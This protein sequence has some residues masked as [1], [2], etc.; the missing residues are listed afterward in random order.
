MMGIA[1][2]LP[3]W[4]LPN[5]PTQPG[6]MPP[7]G[8]APVA[9]A[10]GFGDML[11]KALTQN[12]NMLGMTGLGLL[13]ARTAEQ[14]RQALMNGYLYGSG[15]DAANRKEKREE[16][17]KKRKEAELKAL[18][19]ALAG[20]NPNDPVGAAIASVYPEAAAKAALDARKG[21]T[22]TDEIREYQFDRSQWAAD[23][24]NAGKPFPTFGEWKTN[25]KKAGAINVNNNLPGAE[26][27]FDKARGK[28][29]AEGY[30]KSAEE[31]A[32]ARQNLGLVKELRARL[33]SA[34]E[35]AEG[36]LTGIAARYGIKTKDSSNVE[37]ANAIIAQLV[38]QQRVPG[39]GTTSDRD[40]ELFRQA[41][42]ALMNTRKGNEI[43]LNTMEAAAQDRIARA[44]I[45][46]RVLRGEIS[47]EAGL[48]A[49]EALPDPFEAFRSQAMGEGGAPTRN[50]GG[51]AVPPVR[52]APMV[53]PDGRPR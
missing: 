43:I 51:G 31:L 21:P 50:P 24:N 46:N 9:P 17:E 53:G 44:E 40:L 32:P 1:D 37:A 41:V 13:T 36:A 22:P 34:P 20:A 5:Q 19:A 16:E 15:M 2:Y 26:G 3:A 18:K 29:L 11:N 45:A 6:M 49:L 35:G 8:G 23:P 47:K 27:E 4:M 42:P 30:L 14:Q 28:G 7:E 48:K 33:S 52:L 38:P 10:G 25:L 39:A 12:T